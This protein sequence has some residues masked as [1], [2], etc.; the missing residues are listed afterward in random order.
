MK[1]VEIHSQTPNPRTIRQAAEVLAKG[2]IVAY[3][4]DTIY[5]L[6]CDITNRKAVQRLYRARDLDPRHP[7]AFVC[8]DLRHLG[9]FAWVSK[10]QYKTLKRVLPGPFTFVLPA[11]RDVPKHMVKKKREV[12]IRV[13][14]HAVPLALIAELGHPIIST[15]CGVH[16]GTE[17][18]IDTP[19]DIEEVLGDRIDLLLD[20][21]E[22]SGEP[23]TVVSL[24]DDRVDVLRVGRG[25]PDLL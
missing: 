4:T 2:G 7:L 8:A 25:D 16:P 13:P 9:E 11:S 14:D 3:P 24:I 1:R 23:S 12:G 22:G 18:A 19:D 17:V 6:G 5:G 15:S 21:G 10:Y 20:A